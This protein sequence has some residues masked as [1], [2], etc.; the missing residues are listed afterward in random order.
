VEADGI[1]EKGYFF[2]PIAEDMGKLIG[3]E[4]VL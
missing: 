2:V 1:P 4:E 3:L